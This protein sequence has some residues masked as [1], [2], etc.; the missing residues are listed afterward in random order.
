MKYK[1]L[2][3]KLIIFDNFKL[4]C[5]ALAVESIPDVFKSLN[6]HSFKAEFELNLYYKI[7]DPL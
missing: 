1:F 2:K 3:G 5:L 7:C 6:S 4:I